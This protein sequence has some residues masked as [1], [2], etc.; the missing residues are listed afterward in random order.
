MVVKLANLFAEL[1][2]HQFELSHHCTVV[3]ARDFKVD[4]EFFRDRARQ[5]QWLEGRIEELLI[6]FCGLSID[7][8]EKLDGVS[9]RIHEHTVM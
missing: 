3:Q 8:I 2:T 1:V 9:L 7:V 5:R 4:H 6:R